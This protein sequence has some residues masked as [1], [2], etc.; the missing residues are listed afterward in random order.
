MFVLVSASL[1]WE[2][3]NWHSG[4]NLPPTLCLQCRTQQLCLYWWAR[5]AR[6]HSRAWACWCRT[7][8]IVAAGA[9]LTAAPVWRWSLQYCLPWDVDG[10]YLRDWL[11]IQAKHLKMA[12]LTAWR[13]RWPR[14]TSRS[15]SWHCQVYCYGCS[16]CVNETEWERHAKSVQEEV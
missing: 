12:V 6:E 13:Y 3:Y 9:A 7:G 2:V 14:A 4:L 8:R 1:S 11:L 15:L 16:Q 10:G 5:G